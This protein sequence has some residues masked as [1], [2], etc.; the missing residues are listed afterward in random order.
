MDTDNSCYED[1]PETLDT[2]EDEE[3][4]DGVDYMDEYDQMRE[5]GIGYIARGKD[6]VK[7]I[8]TIRVQSWR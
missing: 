8:D 2:D 5:V 3:D 1:C 4:D 6:V 7:L